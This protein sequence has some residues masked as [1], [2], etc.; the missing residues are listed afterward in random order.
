MKPASGQP[1]VGDANSSAAPLLDLPSCEA[2]GMSLHSRAVV[3]AVPAASIT[4]IPMYP[5]CSGG[6]GAGHAGAVLLQCCLLAGL[7]EW[8][9]IEWNWAATRASCKRWDGGCQP[10]DNFP[11][12]VISQWGRVP[13]ELWGGG[14][15]RGADDS[16]N[17]K[18][19][20]DPRLWLA[21][22]TLP[23]A[24]LGQGVANRSAPP[25]PPSLQ[26]HLSR[27][28]THIH[29]SSLSSTHPSRHHL[30]TL[31]SP[32]IGPVLSHPT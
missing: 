2:G 16:E 5:R 9:I 30:P 19:G 31:P 6:G 18:V 23:S 25:L 15:R 28:H 11:A 24:T 10:T 20:P 26:I 21:T 14:G 8:R 13:I 3:V 29:P 22:G 32:I 7:T 17:L 12:C 27:H 1:A 4:R